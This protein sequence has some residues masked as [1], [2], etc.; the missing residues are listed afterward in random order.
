MI[1]MIVNE[2]LYFKDCDIVRF[3]G[4]WQ[5]FPI[6]RP[7]YFPKLRYGDSKF[8]KKQQRKALSDFQILAY[9][10]FIENDG[11]LLLKNVLDYPTIRFE[12]SI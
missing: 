10:D 6:F 4:F 5:S 9:L 2:L 3:Y 11:V 8:W 7:T 1:E 12:C